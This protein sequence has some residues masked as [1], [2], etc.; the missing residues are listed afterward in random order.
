MSEFK[1]IKISP[2]VGLANLFYKG[3]QVTYSMLKRAFGA[4]L[5]KLSPKNKQVLKKILKNGG[6]INT[7]DFITE[8]RVTKKRVTKKRVTKKRVTKKRV[9]KKRVTKKRV[10]KKRSITKKKYNYDR[11]SPKYSATEY[12]IG[13]IKTGNDGNKYIVKKT[14]NSQRWIKK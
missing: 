5:D 2:K 10:T 1:N 3:G 7:R 9:T 13:T 6:F 8:K 4:S 12:S 14:S 11:P